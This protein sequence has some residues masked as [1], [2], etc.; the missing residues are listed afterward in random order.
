MRDCSLRDLRLGLLATRRIGVE[1]CTKIEP[2]VR[3]QVRGASIDLVT[4]AGL[5]VVELPA[6]VDMLG[7]LPREHERHTSSADIAAEVVNARVVAVCKQSN[8]VVEAAANQGAPMAEGAPACLQREGDVRHVGLRIALEV[9]LQLRGSAI[10][11]VH[12]TRGEEQQLLTSG[13][14]CNGLRQRRLL[15]HDMRVGAAYTEGAHSGT[16]RGRALGP[17]ALRRVDDERRTLN[18]QLRIG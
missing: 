11:R 17:G 9:C 5:G 6:H 4:E 7:A 18:T 15:E 14:R 12:I 16:P 1:Y 8:G 3:L 10:E 2:E 13:G